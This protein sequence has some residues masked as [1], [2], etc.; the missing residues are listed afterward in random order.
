MSESEDQILKKVD[1][2]QRAALEKYSTG[3]I[4]VEFLAISFLFTGS[5]ASTFA[6]LAGDMTP[7]PGDGTFFGSLAGALVT[8][9]MFRLNLLRLMLLQRFTG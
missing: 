8:I 4:V 7:V 3:R 1:A 9:L 5:I 2:H 6:S